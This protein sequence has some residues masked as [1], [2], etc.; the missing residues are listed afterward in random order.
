[1]HSSDLQCEIEELN[2]VADLVFLDIE[3]RK[4]GEEVGGWDHA[5][6]M[7]VSVAVTFS[8]ATGRFHIFE[9]DE[10]EFLFEQLLG[11]D[12][13][14]GYNIRK[15]DYQVLSRYAEASLAALPTLDL[16]DDIG[17]MAGHRVK[18]DNLAKTT[19]GEAK[20]GS[21]LDAVR[22]FQEGSMYELVKY[23]TQD[24]RITRDLYRHG[25]RHG[26]V[27]FKESD[28]SRR[29]VGVNWGRHES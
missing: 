21:G 9:E 11:A 1:M 20:A 28:G 18:L 8:T 24:V 3:T 2:G 15:F 25:E 17:Q 16:M 5:E 4:T 14:I 22:L 29:E 12:L 7:R 27:T 19:L 26:T 6:D 13:V 10:L 23:C